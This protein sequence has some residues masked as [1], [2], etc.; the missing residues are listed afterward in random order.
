MFYKGEL[1]ET[2]TENIDIIHYIYKPVVISIS[3]LYFF[4]LLMIFRRY[5]HSHYLDACFI[6]YWTCIDQTYYIIL[7]SVT[8]PDCPP[9][10]QYRRINLCMLLFSSSLLAVGYKIEPVGNEKVSISQMLTF[11]ADGILRYFPGISTLLYN[12]ILS[13]TPGILNLV[14]C[15]SRVGLACYLSQIPDY[16]IYAIIESLRSSNSH[17]SHGSN[18]EICLDNVDLPEESMCCLFFLIHR[19]ECDLYFKHNSSSDW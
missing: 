13:S 19:Y 14:D 16:H 12:G 6:R 9:T 3:P 1:I 18:E 8:H 15:W 10:K 11:D 4:L 2:L 7:S 17:L 5:I